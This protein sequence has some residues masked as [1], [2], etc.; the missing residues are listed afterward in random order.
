VPSLCASILAADLARLAEEVK[1]VEPHA[2]EFHVDVMDAHLMPPLT[3]GPVVVAS[4]RRATDRALHGHLLVESPEALIGELAEARADVVSF[5][6]EARSDPAP[7]I[8]KAREAGIGVGL[9]VGLQTPLT[10]ID[11]FLGEVDRVTVL[12]SHAERPG[13]FDPGALPRVAAAR[14][15]VDRRGARVEIGAEGGITFAEARRCVDAGASVVVA[16]A[17]IFGA[18]DPA[19]AARELAAIVKGGR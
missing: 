12:C 11:P 6:I 13:A 10:A 19:G 4:L 16:G 17:A 9:S 1:L 5:A 8:R 15:A 7:V 18:D 2:D 3:I 14:A